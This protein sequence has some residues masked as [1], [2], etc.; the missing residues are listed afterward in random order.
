MNKEFH[1]AELPV[2]DDILTMSAMKKINVLSVKNRLREVM[3]DYAEKRR[4][5]EIEKNKSLLPSEKISIH[6]EHLKSTLVWEFSYTN[7]SFNEVVVNF[8]N[9]FYN[10]KGAV[11]RNTN[12][13][14][15][16]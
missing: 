10:L 14:C 3:D 12:D 8:V 15:R 2:F 16:R 4:A 11:Q 9:L 13:T 1:P 6:E 7:K 5:E